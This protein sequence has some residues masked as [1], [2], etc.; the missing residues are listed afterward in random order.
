MQESRV[1]ELQKDYKKLI[2]E[3][4]LDLKTKG[5]RSRQI[6][7]IL[8]VARIF[9]PFFII[10]AAI[11]HNVIL[12][13]I[14]VVI[15]SITD[16]FDGYIARKYNF[17]S[18]L[19]KDLDAICDKVFAVTL[20]LAASFFEPVLIINFLLELAIASVNMKAK[21]KRYNPSSHLMGKAKTCFLYILIGLG[22]LNDYINILELFVS[23]FLMTT[24]MQLTTTITY[25]FKY[26]E[27]K[28][29]ELNKEQY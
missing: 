28:M 22:F 13:C 26:R 2:D 11:F 18:E 19:G 21:L 15:F 5:R 1:K 4:I 23:M 9:A 16:A 10:P 6:P 12:I 29:K 25:M 24:I 14:F 3:A 27:S 7:N 17:V 8:T 20:L